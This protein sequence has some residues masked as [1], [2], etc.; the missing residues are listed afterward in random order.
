[1]EIKVHYMILMSTYIV[2]RYRETQ[3]STKPTWIMGRILD[4]LRPISNSTITINSLFEILKGRVARILR[5]NYTSSIMTT[6][7]NNF[8][9]INTFVKMTRSNIKAQL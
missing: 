5:T 4:G 2:N 1:M 8:V 7:I 3:Q 9:T 6:T